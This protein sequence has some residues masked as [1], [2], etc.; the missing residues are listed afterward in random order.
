MRRIGRTMATLKMAVLAMAALK[1]AGLAAAPA[2]AQGAP[3]GFPLDRT[4]RGISI[5]GFDV[6]RAGLTLTARFDR[7][8]KRVTGSGSAG[9][10]T[11]RAT[12]LFRFDNRFAAS[13]VVTTR[14]R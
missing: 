12:F 8:A 14:K 1:M 7:N 5:S 9:C 10:N 3:S 11:W 6:Q 4:F 2:L 13:E